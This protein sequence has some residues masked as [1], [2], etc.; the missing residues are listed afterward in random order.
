MHRL[1]SITA[2]TTVAAVAS[3]LTGSAHAASNWLNTFDGTGDEDWPSAMVVH[4]GVTYVAGSTMGA[5]GAPDGLVLAYDASGTELWSTTYAGLP[6]DDEYI[7]RLLDGKE[8]PDLLR[9]GI[10]GFISE[11]AMS[12]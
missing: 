11:N 5:D 6:A 9:V 3:L 2:A 1:T 4:G 7:Q 10:I 8:I 12:E